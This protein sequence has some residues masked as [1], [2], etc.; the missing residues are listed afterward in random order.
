M[1]NLRIIRNTFIA[2]TLTATL[3]SCSDDDT[4]TPVVETSYKENITNI[5]NNVIVETY[6]DLAGKANDLFTE[7]S[8]FKNNTTAS[9]LDEAKQAWRSTRAPWEQSEGFLFGPVDTGGI[10]PAIDSWPVNTNDMDALLADTANHPTITEA[11]VD[12]QINE[13][14]GFHLIEYILWGVDGNKQAADFTTRELEYLVAACENLK[15]KTATLKEAWVS[16]GGNYVANF[17]NAGASGIYT[18]EKSALEDLVT[19]MI[20]IADEVANGKINTP[21]NGDP[22]TG[23]PAGPEQEESRFSHNS[24]LD[25]ANNVRSISN[26]YNGKF[27]IDGKGISEVV[28]NKDSSLDTQF[29]DELVAA[30]QAIEAI[31]GTFSA[32]LSSNRTAIETAQTKVRT[33]QETLES[34]IKPL[35]SGL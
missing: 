9:N 31:S 3:V 4:P 8:D 18:S 1:K 35:I 27:S 15:N 22:S 13:A 26:V 10:D 14:K 29:K 6:S 21:L 24:K 2:F 30:I 12:Q 17:L 5:A 11:I 16:N 25:F 34:K 19:G 23:T 33:V 32:A 28:A 7:A 20:G